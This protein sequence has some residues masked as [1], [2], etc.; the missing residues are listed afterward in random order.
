MP[1][2]AV[3]CDQELLTGLGD[4][5]ASSR[6]DLD[7]RVHSHLAEN[8]AEIEQVRKMFGGKSYADVYRDSGLLTDRTIMAHCV[9]LRQDEMAAMAETGA[10]SLTFY[11][12]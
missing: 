7:L 12:Q 8:H 11:W 1:R 2:F 3:C 5:V 10:T 6:C 4:L 9:H